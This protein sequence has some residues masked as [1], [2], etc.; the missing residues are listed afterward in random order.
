MA[1][2]VALLG[3]VALTAGAGARRTDTAVRRFT[4]ATHSSG[5]N[6]SPVFPGMDRLPPVASVDE[7]VGEPV[8]RVLPDGAVDPHFPLPTAGVDR[9]FLYRDYGVV[10]RAGR[11]P[12]PVRPDEALATVAAAASDHLAVGGTVTLRDLTGILSRSHPALPTTLPPTV[13]KPLRLT[14]VGIGV[15]LDDIAAAS[16]RSQGGSSGFG[17]IDLTPAYVAEHGGPAA[18]V[19]TGALVRLRPGATV[20]RFRSELDGVARL[21]PDVQ[22]R[23]NYD[24]SDLSVTVAALQRTVRPDV[25]SMWL[26]ALLVGLATVLVLGQ[27]LRRRAWAAA[28]DYPVLRALGMTRR[29]FVVGTSSTATAAVVAGAAGAVVIAILA[30][31]LTPVGP[32]RVAE[33]DPGIAV[34][35]AVLGVG[36]VTMV[37]L[38]VGQVVWSAWRS[39][40]AATLGPA[41]IE[42]SRLAERVAATGLPAP[43]TVGLRFAIVPGRGASAAPLRSTVAS[44]ALA[45]VT[46][47]VAVTFNG[48]LSR[49]SSTPQRH[50]WDWDLAVDGGY[51]PLPAFALQRALSG[52]RG[53]AGWSGGNYGA[54]VLDGQ[55]VPA[56]GI[57]RLHGSVF[58]S[59]LA[60]RPPRGA[61]EIAL[62]SSTMRAAH[63]SVGGRVGTIVAG[64]VRPLLVSGRVVLPDFE[65]GGFAA[66]DLGTGAVGTSQ[67]VHP[68]GIPA[69]ATY[70]F[71]LV[72]YQPGADAAKT[73]RAV[74][75]A[76]APICAHGFCNEFTDRRPHEI[77]SYGQVA[78]TPLLLSVVLGIL[79]AAGLAHALVTS[80]RQRRR[81]IAVLKTIGFTR[82]QVSTTVAWQSSAFV[83]AVLVVGLPVGA[84]AGRWVWALF[85]G[86]LGVATDSL[87]PWVFLVATVPAAVVAA[88]LVALGPAWSAGRIRAA[89]A[90]R[91]E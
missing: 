33:P 29:Q 15:G 37:V 45:L 34:N 16:A 48:N 19:Y 83:T 73:Q 81:D 20:A 17:T 86:Q 12:D 90:L 46:M 76:L 66:T 32:A 13:G 50:G 84:V 1:V 49:L 68:A 31:P 18:A 42:A 56:V 22:S 53:V 85:A 55:L 44:A 25:V 3:S 62:G 74:T 89:V 87:L 77:N 75:A 35:A 91:S 14:I 43:A 60:G 52:V 24:I 26:F 5:F 64:V 70:N 88:N 30:S 82:R 79:A 23:T 58:P 61:S 7:L 40:V 6:V 2:L 39:S 78:W 80:V 63:T 67:L 27:A 47:V 28:A 41:P 38:L 9:G 65:R 59:V 8:L 57:D 54:V 10:L 36:A 11:L 71:F 4:A 51:V 72:R 69:G 21:H